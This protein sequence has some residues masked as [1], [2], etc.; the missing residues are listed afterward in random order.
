MKMSLTV[1]ADQRSFLFLPVKFHIK[2]SKILF[3]NCREFIQTFFWDSCWYDRLLTPLK[4]LDVSDCVHLKFFTNRITG[5]NPIRRTLLYLP[6][7]KRSPKYNVSFGFA[8]KITQILLHIQILSN[9]IGKWL[10]ED[11]FTS[12]LRSYHICRSY[13]HQR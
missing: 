2:L 7:V 3:K 11:V 4:Q 8:E 5:A 1:V 13:V 9:R 6:P 10:F 12:N